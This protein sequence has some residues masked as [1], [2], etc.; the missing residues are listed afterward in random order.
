MSANIFELAAASAFLDVVLANKDCGFMELFRLISLPSLTRG[1]GNS[2]VLPRCFVLKAAS[3]CVAGD[4][5]L[6][7]GEM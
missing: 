2:Y 5:M 7:E 1:G 6:S 4:M 3:F